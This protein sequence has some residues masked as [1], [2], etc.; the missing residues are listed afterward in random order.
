MNISNLS[1][2]TIHDVFNNPPGSHVEGE[3]AI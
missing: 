2:N 1:N 3:H